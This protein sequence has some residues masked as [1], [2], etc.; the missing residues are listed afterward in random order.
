M[1]PGLAGTGTTLGF[2]G[3]EQGQVLDAAT[4]L[5]GR[6]IAGLRVSFVD[7]RARHSGISHHTLTALTVA[8]HSRVTVALP[9]LPANL[10]EKLWAQLNQHRISERHAIVSAEGRPGLRLLET[11]GI[12]VESM[13]RSM[14][15]APE[16]VLAAAAAGA[17]AAGA[18]SDLDTR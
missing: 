18:I 7:G 3:I 17:V 15:V 13:G 2:S 14:T 11:K 8:T 16:G 5:N 9:D 12:E 1:G 10:S 6:P 4:A